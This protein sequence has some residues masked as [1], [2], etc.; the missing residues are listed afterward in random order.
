MDDPAAGRPD[1]FAPEEQLLLLAVRRPDR[2]N[3][4]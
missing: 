2:P 3:G 1:P 4:G